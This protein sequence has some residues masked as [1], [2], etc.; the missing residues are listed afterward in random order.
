M[1]RA[2][3]QA[4]VLA[5]DRLSTDGECAFACRML[6]SGLTLIDIA[7]A[8]GYSG[9][10]SQALLIAVKFAH[11]VWKYAPEVATRNAPTQDWRPAYAAALRNWAKGEAR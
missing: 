5:M 9:T 7:R 10:D 1:L 8:Y 11:F 3:L 6:L 2:D 4:G